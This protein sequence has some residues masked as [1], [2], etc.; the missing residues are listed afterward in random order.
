MKF[1]D[2]LEKL[3]N[4][5]EILNFKFKDSQVP[6]YL[7]IRFTLMQSLINKEFNLSNPHV[8]SNKKSI[9]DIFKYIFYT[10]KSNLFFAPKRDIYIFSSGIVNK[11][12]DGKYI[13]RLYDDFYNLFQ[14]Q[15]QVIESSV[16]FSYLVPKKAKVYFRDF[17]DIIIVL[18]SKVVKVKS[19]D[20]INIENF[21]KYLQNTILLENDDYLLEEIKN[22]LIK[23]SKRMNFSFWIYK[24]F[25]KI[26]KPKIIIVEDAHY[27]GHMSLIK[28]A[29]SLGIKTA[30]YQHG[31]VGLAH[32]AYNYHKN[33]FEDIKEFLP[34]FFLTHGDYWKNVVRTSSKKI[35]IGFVELSKK[36]SKI[37]TIQEKKKKILFISG[38]TV[39]E[40]LNEL[41]AKSLSSLHEL[42]YEVLLRPHPSEIPAIDVRY[43]TLIK[44]GVQI[45]TNNL[46][47]TLPTVEIVVGME[48]STVVYE[49]IC[50]T[51]RVYLMDTEYTKFYEPESCFISFVNDS[52]LI[53]SV[54]E[55]KVVNYDANYFWD[56]NW[57]E[58]YQ[59][60]IEN[61][62]G[63][64]YDN[65]N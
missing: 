20:L 59:N 46:Y 18:G 36:V 34:E 60:F 65:N 33:I 52:D 3:E 61:T 62:I 44:Q 10:L 11:L 45:D 50:F 40:A 39:F 47:A 54:K 57:Q 8:K 32:P 23:L 37:E 48:V 29:K 64:K 4:N 24:Q 22:S 17:I 25:L 21:I 6:M 2:I 9:R 56:K 26:K 49:A 15:T 1:D 31:Y 51:K 14:N 27:L 5:R 28:A 30:E 7:T 16:K 58:N 42:G 13:N 53:A 38:G 12:E 43:A 41:V 35:P 55:E 63:I 19:E